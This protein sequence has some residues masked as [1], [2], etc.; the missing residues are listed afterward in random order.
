MPN[1]WRISRCWGCFGLLW[2][3]ALM[4]GCGPDP[5]ANAVPQRARPLSE[6][7]PG[8]TSAATAEAVPPVDPATAEYRLLF[9]GN[10]HTAFNDIPGMVARMIGQDGSGER[11]YAERAPSF[12]FLDDAWKNPETARR[13]RERPWTHVILQAQKYSQSRQFEYSTKE[14]IEMAKFVQSCGGQVIFF[15]EW[16]QRGNLDEGQFV[17]QL[18]LTLA[19]EA[20]GRVAPVGPAWDLA[21]SRSVSAP[22]HAPDGNHASM[23]GG[24]LTAA[25]LYAAITNRDPA[26]IHPDVGS[27]LFR[28]DR[29]ILIRAASEAWT[30]AAK[31]KASSEKPQSSD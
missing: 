26:G 24:F 20:G 5:G 22:L 28:E 2:F 16:G 6:A 25:V 3:E 27:Q 18:H 9:F 29:E 12:G 30:A 7:I 19:Q 8:T 15:P 11:A 31:A 1:V 17:Y 21:L 10:S 4:L 14:A 13:I 23:E